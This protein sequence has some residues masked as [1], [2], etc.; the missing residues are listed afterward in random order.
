MAYILFADI[1]RFPHDTIDGETVLIDSEKGYLFLFLGIGPQ[2]WE[3]LLA[4]TS[5]E[6]LVNEVTARYGAAA[7]APTRAFLDALEQAQ[8]L[9]NEPSPS[10][11]PA[12]ASTA[13]PETFVAPTLE[14]YDQIADIISMDPI[15]EVD[16]NKGWPHHPSEKA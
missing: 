8:M 15:H 16:P 7:A 1:G 9:R 11:A 3:H 6:A 12:S 4:G 2:L 10:A 5:D 13:W 14:R